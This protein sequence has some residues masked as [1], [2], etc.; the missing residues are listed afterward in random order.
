MDREDLPVISPSSDST[1]I[2]GLHAEARPPAPKPAS[3]PSPL[4]SP[5][6]TRRAVTAPPR[7]AAPPP[8]APVG[9]DEEDPEKLLREYADR[10]KNK[11]G[12]IEQDL[13]RTVGERDSFKSKGETLAK[14]LHDARTQLQMIPK[15]EETI[16]DLQQ[17]VD[18]ALLSNGMAQA[19]NSKLK[20]KASDLEGNLRKAEERA[21]HAEKS[22][23]DTQGWLKQQ[24]QGR[25][26]A[27]QRIAIALQTLQGK[28]GA[29]PAP[30]PA[31]K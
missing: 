25:L 7:P 14:E 20:L 12:R 2:E 29:A 15:L 1:K 16:K 3:A 10:Q 4:K 22:L 23:A 8:P 11:I 17:K 5:T 18:A 24:T 9:R 26:E 31:K 30:A 27:E 6:E 28:V 21:A 19:E 13:Q